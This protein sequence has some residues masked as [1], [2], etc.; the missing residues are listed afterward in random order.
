MSQRKLGHPIRSFF[1]LEVV[2]TA[3]VGY[4]AIC[5][6][7]ALVSKGVDSRLLFTVYPYYAFTIVPHSFKVLLWSIVAVFVFRRNFGWLFP[8]VVMM[9]YGIAE[10]FSSTIFLL[11]HETFNLS[12]YLVWFP[13]T[14][15]YWGEFLAFIT[16]ALIG[17]WVARPKFKLDW[18]LLP[19]SVFVIG[20]ALMGYE[21]EISTFATY[22]Q[23]AFEFIW[24]VLYLL[25]AS[26]VIVR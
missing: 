22:Q 20:W 3:A 15:V 23:E 21:T 5:A 14:S 6:V 7:F 24:N 26:Q 8:F 1:V 13:P 4:L 12:Y 10:A 16:I 25:A 2:S 19:F 9:A 17:Y 18:A 11:V